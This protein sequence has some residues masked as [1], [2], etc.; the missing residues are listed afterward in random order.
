[1]RFAKKITQEMVERIVADAIMINISFFSSFILRFLSYFIFARDFDKDAFYYRNLLKFFINS[2]LDNFWIL[3]PICLLIFYLSGFYT[4]GRF[5]KGKFKA[6]IIFQAISLSY[7]LF[8]F[9]IYFFRL[10]F[11]PRSV[12]VISWIISLITVG[13][14]RLWSALWRKAAW[15][16][17]KIWG[18]PKTI[19]INNILIIGGAGY[20]GS[21]LTR[22]LLEKGYYVT[23]LDSLL[24][25]DSSLKEL[26][27]NN[28]FELI[29]GDM[30]N[31]EAV[32]K[33]MQYNDAVIHLGALVG[34]PACAIDENLTLEINLAATRMIGELARGF[35]LK[36][37]IF[38]STCS[39]YGAS[40]EI[41]NE[42]SIVNPLS[43]YAK[44]KLA[45]EEALF[46]LSNESF[47][48]TVLRF[49][50]VYGLSPRPRFDLVVNLL[51]A[52]ATVDKSITIF[53]GE[54]W[55]PFVH[56]DD[57]A[58]AIVLCLEVPFQL[59][60]GEIFNVGSDQ[61]NYK[62]SQLGEIVKQLFPE[63]KVINEDKNIDIRNYKVSF[64]KIHK[65]LG[66]KPRRSIIDGMLEIKEA[67]ENGIVNNYKDLKYSNYKTLLDEY[68]YQ[69]LKSVN[70]NFLYAPIIEHINSHN[71]GG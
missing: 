50:T 48:C 44:T 30:R 38:A 31:V 66:F 56:V 28:K 25:G 5:Y 8:F 10:S 22:K 2:Y 34:D 67:I 1:M 24:Y 59:I 11:L 18:K 39:V 68:N 15:S 64:A 3:T 65:L 42:K 52:K 62:L 61:Q 49:A 36:R 13:G 20:I 57:V 69:L 7:L 32:A 33:A 35:G 6:L 29:K 45:S 63:V 14:L 55:R 26:F 23:V 21:I 37:F 27:G 4:Y 19:S 17:V 46:K 43:I 58:E 51:A 71:S 60:N 70:I 53:G 9:I 16:E 41:L 40:N 12:L 54:Q 47:C